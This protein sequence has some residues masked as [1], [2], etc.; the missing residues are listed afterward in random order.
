MKGKQEIQNQIQVKRK[1][2]EMLNLSL[3]KSEKKLK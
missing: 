1:I 3:L 2:K